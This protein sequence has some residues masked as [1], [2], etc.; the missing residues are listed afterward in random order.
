MANRGGVEGVL[1]RG[2]GDRACR[3][4][5]GG[6]VED[7]ARLVDEYDGTLAMCPG[8][9]LSFESGRELGTLA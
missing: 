3:A 1:G 7:V 6:G 8:L 5:S 4:I 2:S 9:W